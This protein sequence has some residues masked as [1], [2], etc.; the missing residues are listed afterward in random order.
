MALLSPSFDLRLN[1]V[2]SP[3][4]IE[5]WKTFLHF[6]HLFFNRHTGAD[7]FWGGHDSPAIHIY[8]VECE[9]QDQWYF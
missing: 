1:A 7:L 6:Q 5:Q 4:S 9:I 8:S 2:F 3:M